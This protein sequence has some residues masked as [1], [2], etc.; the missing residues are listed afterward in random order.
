MTET[1]ID[2]F[3]KK[4]RQCLTKILASTLSP[5]LASSAHGKTAEEESHGIENFEIPTEGL[6]DEESL[7]Y[8]ESDSHNSNVAEDS[9]IFSD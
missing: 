9:K 5:S 6:I 4:L 1:D 7:S 2:I 3:I 8:P